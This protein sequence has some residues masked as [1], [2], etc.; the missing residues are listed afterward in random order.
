MQTTTDRATA[1]FRLAGREQLASHTSR[2]LA[3]SDSLSS[4]Q[5]HESVFNNFLANL[6]LTNRTWALPELF[7]HIQR[8]VGRE[9]PAAVTDLPED[10]TVRFSELDPIV[11]QFRDDRIHLSVSLA[12]IS[13]EERSW[14]NVEFHVKYQLVAEGMQLKLL[15]DGQVSLR[16][17]HSGRVDVVLRTIGS[18]L[19]PRDE[20][21]KLIPENVLQDQRLQGLVWSQVQLDN[22]W[23]GLGIADEKTILAREKAAIVR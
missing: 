17:D 2:P 8:K 7:A 14:E 21:R 9:K 18:K 22:A 19:F 12:E 6:E 16:G 13:N 20:P 4:M 10:V 23:L 3:L 11:V 1:R 15:R 5:V